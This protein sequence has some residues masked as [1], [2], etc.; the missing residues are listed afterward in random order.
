M[1][2][3]RRPD[4]AA[5]IGQE[6]KVQVCLGHPRVDRLLRVEALLPDDH[7]CVLG[8]GLHFDVDVGCPV[9]NRPLERVERR[10]HGNPDSDDGLAT[11]SLKPF[12]FQCRG[13]V[14]HARV[15]RDVNDVALDRC[16]RFGAH[17][18]NSAVIEHTQQY[19]PSLPV[20]KG[21]NRLVDVPLNLAAAALK[22]EVHPLASPDIALQL[23]VHE[24]SLEFS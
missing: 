16:N 4:L 6:L 24:A 15:V 10:P 21:A 18:R 19:G 9:V 23:R 8:L 7:R 1:I 3:T 11:I 12:E 5:D 2:G 20:R 14:E 17:T 13:H 22:L